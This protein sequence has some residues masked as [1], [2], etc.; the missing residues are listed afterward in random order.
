MLKL[1]KGFLLKLLAV[2]TICCPMFVFA[3]NLQSADALLQ[4]YAPVP[5]VKVA[6]PEVKKEVVGY[7]VQDIVKMLPIYVSNS[8]SYVSLNLDYYHRDQ[9]INIVPN[10][11]TPEEM[12]FVAAR[13][14]AFNSNNFGNCEEFYLHLNQLEKNFDI[15]RSR[16][17]LAEYT[18]RQYLKVLFNGGRPPY[19]ENVSATQSLLQRLQNPE[20]FSGHRSTC[21]EHEKYF[22]RFKEILDAVTQAAPAIVEQNKRI[23]QAIRDTKNKEYEDVAAKSAARE[24]TRNACLNSNQYKLYSFSQ[25]IAGNRTQIAWAQQ[26]IEREK[27]GAKISGYVNKQIMYEKGNQIASLKASNE[28][29]F[30]YYKAAGGTAKNIDSVNAISV[31]PCAEL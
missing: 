10:V 7:T 17:W 1:K 3:E 20:T 11:P 18:F 21:E 31:N 9:F 29:K 25:M 4:K 5:E 15:M 28:E 23:A 6:Q 8:G 2:A 27:A 14:E 26:V 24:K 13:V 16:D 22:V 12:L 19:E 30:K